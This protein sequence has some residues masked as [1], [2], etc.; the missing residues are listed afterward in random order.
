VVPFKQ[1]AATIERLEGVKAAE[2]DFEAKVK[3]GLK[4]PTFIQAMVDSGK[5]LEV[6]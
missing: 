2:A 3:G 6:D 1:I 5:F 4:V